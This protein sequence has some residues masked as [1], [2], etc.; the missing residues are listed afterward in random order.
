MKTQRH[1]CV[2]HIACG[3]GPVHVRFTQHCWEM[4]TLWEAHGS[5]DQGRNHSGW[6]MQL[7]ILNST[8]VLSHSSVCADEM[9]V[10]WDSLLFCPGPLASSLPFCYL[11]YHPALSSCIVMSVRD[12][13]LP[14]DG[15]HV[16]PS[17]LPAKA[18]EAPKIS[19]IKG[20][21]YGSPLPVGYF[22]LYDILCFW[23][24]SPSS[25]WGHVRSGLWG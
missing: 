22:M 21:P 8:P 9:H 25:M 24:L 17:F 2:Q 12:S 11:C 13:W 14:Y 4:L 5:G 3:K 15:L 23:F 6:Q 16:L 10:W 18:V 20:L 1:A 19:Q 7:H